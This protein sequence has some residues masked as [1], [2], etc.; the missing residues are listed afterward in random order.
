MK[1][2]VTGDTII[3]R[4]EDISFERLQQARNWR[5]AKLHFRCGMGPCQ[6]RISGPAVRYLFGWQAESVR[7][8]IFPCELEK[9][10]TT[11]EI[12]Y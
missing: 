9:L 8:P 1:N 11:E 12:T 6:G 2:A 10:V 5:E 3:C 4:C 7:P